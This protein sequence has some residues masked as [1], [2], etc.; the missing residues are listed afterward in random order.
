MINTTLH[1]KDNGVISKI[2]FDIKLKEYWE[3]NT[4][5]IT[6]ENKLSFKTH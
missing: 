6:R 1:C 3:E 2:L 4:L 5:D